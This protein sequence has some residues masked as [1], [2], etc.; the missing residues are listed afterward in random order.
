M[1]KTSLP[2]KRNENIVSS[3]LPFPEW[4]VNCPI[5]NG[6]YEMFFFFTRVNKG[7]FMI[8]LKTFFRGSIKVTCGFLASETIQEI[9]RIRQ[10]SRKKNDDILHIINKLKVLRVI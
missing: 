4:D 2:I 7:I 10:F 9:V 8:S 6:T 1:Q 3:K 5:R